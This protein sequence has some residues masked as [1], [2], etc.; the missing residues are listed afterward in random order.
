MG[1]SAGEVEATL[2]L[3]DQMSSGMTGVV[4]KAQQLRNELRNLDTMAKN[5]GVSTDNARTKMEKESVVLE[6]LGRRGAKASDA[7]GALKKAQ[8]EMADQAQRAA[9]A[10]AHMH[11]ALDAARAKAT[12]LSDVGRLMTVGITAPIVGASTAALHFAADFETSMTRVHTLSGVSTGDMQMM[13]QAILDMAP[14]VGIGPNELAKAMLFVTSTG[15]KGAAAVDILRRSAE[16]SAVGMGE[17]AT[18]A[19]TLVSIIKAYGSENMTAAKATEIMFKTVKDGNT[20]AS[21]LAG[22]LGRVIG[23]ASEVGVKF[24]DVG[25]FIATFT[26]LG[27]NSAEAVT[28]LRGTLSEVL[29]PSSQAAKALSE[30]G[31]SFAEVRQQ[32]K[33]KG[34]TRA[35]IELVE[36]F[37]DNDAALAKAFPNVRALAGILGTAGVQAKDFADIEKHLKT[38]TTEMGDAFKATSETMGQKWAQLRA[39]LQVL[40]ISLGEK[41]LPKM[42]EIVPAVENLVTHAINLVKWFSELPK[43]LQTFIEAT[44][45]IGAAGGPVISA[46]ATLLRYWID[47]K[48]AILAAQAAQAG[49]AAVGVGGAVGGGIGLLGGAAA[50]LAVGAGAYAAAKNPQGFYDSLLAGEG[51]GMWSTPGGGLGASVTRQI[52]LPPEILGL[53][54]SGGSIAGASGPGSAGRVSGTTAAEIIGGLMA[55]IIG[56]SHGGTGGI[57]NVPSGSPVLAAALEALAKLQYDVRSKEYGFA[58]AQAGGFKLPA[59]TRVGIGAMPFQFSRPIGNAVTGWQGDGGTSGTMSTGMLMPDMAAQAAERMRELRDNTDQ[60]RESLS[61]LATMF[62]QLGSVSGGALG[63]ILRDVG[64]L[65]IMTSAAKDAG[66]K[67]VLS[68]IGKGGTTT[69]KWANTA[70]GIAAIGQGA[71]DFWA[72]TGSGQGKAKGA[73]SGAASGAKLGTMIMP[74]WG[75]AIGAGVGAVV[76]LVRNMGVSKEE[77]QGREAVAAFEAELSKL[78]TTTQRLEAGGTQWKMTTIAVR[79]AYLATGRSSADAEAAVKKLWDTSKGGADA[80]KK[81]MEEISGVLNE[82]KQDQADLEAAVQKYGFSLDQLGPT[83]QKQKLDE[84]AAGLMNDFRVLT[85]AGID[86]KLVIEK[87]SGALNDYIQTAMRTGVEVP[88]SM[89]PVVEKMIEMGQLTDENGNKLDASALDGIK[90]SET[91]TQGFDRIVK[92]FDELIEKIGLAGKKI[93]DMPSRKDVDINFRVPDEIRAPRFVEGDDF[94]HMASG[95]S[96][97]ASGPTWFY[98]AGNEEYAFSG[99]GRRFQDS[100]SG[101][102]PMLIQL[103]LPN[104]RVLAE[105]VT[106]ETDGKLQRRRLMGRR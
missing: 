95:G 86:Y 69:E 37:G 56:S 8:Q 72:S 87:M 106:R 84:Q 31:L 63:G 90:W 103:V 33:E 66:G 79:D 25:T 105:A 97:Y 70:S 48:F 34:L 26:R 22:T 43:P 101:G 23:I 60:E 81:A 46:L 11:Q 85:A 14:A 21:E 18:I 41:L 30:V 1:I 16:A 6:E 57:A 51:L 38:Q 15:I 12:A 4:S 3:R 54:M 44:I 42:K 27:V 74:G 45:L 75:T 24:E 98:T 59:W 36:R 73:L 78:L 77:K 80:A 62:S 91:M 96:G 53:F 5:L 65:V 88:S 47:I 104:G 19:R 40:A 99:E 17:T 94:K 32:I 61:R 50:G 83:L 68:L 82:Q 9:E 76:G 29:K 64:Q 93:N 58:S 10:Q 39:D 28:A 20:E 89:R 102:G 7:I 2:R 52:N 55:P 67:G 71:M 92:K 13:K 35:L 100:G 49:G